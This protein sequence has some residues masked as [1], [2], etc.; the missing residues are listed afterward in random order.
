MAFGMSVRDFLASHTSADIAELEAYDRLDPFG[1][2]RADYRACLV[3]AVIANANPFRKKN[4]KAVNPM[5]LM[6]QFGD[7]E[8]VSDEEIIAKAKRMCAAFGGSFT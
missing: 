3:A 4:A 5:D 8:P 7:R 6:P 2:T 1:E